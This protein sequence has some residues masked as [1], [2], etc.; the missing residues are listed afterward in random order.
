MLST[1]VNVI[2][3]GQCYLN[4]LFVVGSDGALVHCRGLQ[5]SSDLTHC[6][7]SFVFLYLFIIL[8]CLPEILL[9]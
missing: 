9:F 1:E 3:R 5:V 2:Y 8:K 4:F 6:I 7:V